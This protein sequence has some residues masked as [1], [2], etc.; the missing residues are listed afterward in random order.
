MHRD[1]L[2]THT[3][4]ARQALCGLAPPEG[5]RIVC[6]RDQAGL[7]LGAK[8]GLCCALAWAL[9]PG[10]QQGWRAGGRRSCAGCSLRTDI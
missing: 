3:S 7:L 8:P 10:A 5:S 4:T 1:P 9:P 2:V 6:P